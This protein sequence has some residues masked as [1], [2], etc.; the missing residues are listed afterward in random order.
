[1][2]KQSAGILLYRDAGSS[3]EV[4]LVHP[5][6][7]FWARKD[8]SA[9]SIP[10]GLI[11]PGED[12]LQAA[13]REFAEETGFVPEGEYVPLGVF[14]QPDGKLVHAWAVRGDFDPRQLKSNTFTM[15]WPPK[16][17]QMREFPEVDRAAWF[18][19]E[20]AVR[21]ITKGQR[22]LLATFLSAM[23]AQR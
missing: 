8:D 11:E 16:S 14:R 3:C 21:K 18:A 4:L 2:T 1:M 7:P 23:K 13:K 10:K 6:G 9:W 15:E 19:P 22:P 17:G 20:A 12:P 5:G